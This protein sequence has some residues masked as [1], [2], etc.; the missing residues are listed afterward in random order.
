MV[1]FTGISTIKDPESST[2]F[3]VKLCVKSKFKFSVKVSST[4]HLLFSTGKF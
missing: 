2:F 4:H 1:L 3:N